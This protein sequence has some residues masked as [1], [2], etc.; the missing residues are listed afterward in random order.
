MNRIISRFLLVTLGLAVAGCA[1]V[2]DKTL[3][4]FS[5]NA[6]SFLIVNGAL[7]TGTATL[8][9][10]RTGRLAFT[11]DTGPVS[12]CAGTMRYTASQAGTIDLRCND[13]AIALLKY[14]LITETRGY[15][16]GK[17]ADTPVSLTFGLSAADA[18]AFLTVPEGK[19]L[20]E[21]ANG[22]GLKLEAL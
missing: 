10:D 9:P 14:T 8:I 13:G 20:S 2:N 18:R 1:K 12:G 16:Y 5:T 11:A 4:W 15:A 6:D 22:G 21:D 17:A 3:G 7:L 19:K